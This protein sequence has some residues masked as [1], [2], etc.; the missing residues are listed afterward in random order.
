MVEVER[1][2]KDLLVFYQSMK[3]SKF[4]KLCISN[5]KNGDNMPPETFD[6]S[7]ESG[8]SHISQD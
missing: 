7:N 8:E 6:I 4:F 5:N 2:F 3:A 1:V